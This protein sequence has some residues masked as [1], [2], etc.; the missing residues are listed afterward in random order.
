MSNENFSVYPNPLNGEELYVKFSTTHSTLYKTQLFDVLG[1]Q[2]YLHN[3]QSNAQGIIK[4]NNLQI[5]SG[6]YVLKL[7]NL[8]TGKSY[9][10]KIIKD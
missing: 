6:V 3:I 1:Q 2:V 7:T 5:N 4:M 10:H 8:S 9:T